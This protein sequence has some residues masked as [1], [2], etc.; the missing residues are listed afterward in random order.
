MNSIRLQN[1]RCFEDTGYIDIKPLTFLIGANSSGKSSFLKLLPLLKQS[2]DVKVNG[3]FLWANEDVDFNNFKTALKEGS[4]EM[5]VTMTISDLR[6]A[7]RSNAY[8]SFFPEVELSLKLRPL[9]DN[10]DF[11]S[12]LEISYSDTNIV[13]TYDDT[14]NV[15]CIRVND[16][17]LSSG[18]V[19][20]KN[21][22]TNSLLPKL[23]FYDSDSQY[24]DEQYD[25]LLDKICES[26]QMDPDDV[27]IRRQLLLMGFRKIIDRGNLINYLYRRLP[28]YLRLPQSYI[29]E[30]C[31]MY[32]MYHIN[33]IIDS[34]NMY[35]LSSASNINYVQPVRVFTKRYYRFQNFAVDDIYPDGRNLAMFFNSLSPE[36]MDNLNSWLSS[37]FGFRLTIKINDGSLEIVVTE[38]GKNGKNMVDVGFGYTQCLP[39]LTIIWKVVMIDCVNNHKAEQDRFCDEH[40]IAIEQPELHLHPRFQSFFANMLVKAVQV[41]RKDGKK[42]KFVIETHSPTIIN[43]IGELVATKALSTQDVNVVL[44]NASHEGLHNYV[45][46]TGFTEDG[47][48]LNWPYGFFSHVDRSER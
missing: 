30:V 27:T 17:V 13:I 42:I 2:M 34:L 15:N 46:Q 12:A 40:I 43:K 5:T 33:N 20:M 32:V 22:I 11:L 35:F 41:C 29:N 24:F 21:S 37:I 28:A 26:L 14:F 7:K 45:E 3:V 25:F 6:L 38:P 44:F 1:Y 48:I 18:E 4:E 8:N 39:I 19:K 9:G 36:A 31:D 16:F 23:L 10:F 47:F